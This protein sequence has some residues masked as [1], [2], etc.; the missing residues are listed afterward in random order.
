MV[1]RHISARFWWIACLLAPSLVGAQGWTEDQCVNKAKHF[2]SVALAGKNGVVNDLVIKSVKVEQDRFT[3]YEGEGPPTHLK[4]SIRHDQ[5]TQV[6]IRQENGLIT[7]VHALDSPT[8]TEFNPRHALSDRELQEMALK[9][10]RAAGWKETGMVIFHFGF[11]MD[12]RVRILHLLP[13]VR[14]VPYHWESSIYMELDYATGQLITGNW[15]K[16]PN[17]SPPT[18]LAPRITSEQAIDWAMDFVTRERGVTEAS[19]VWHPLCVCRVQDWLEY[20]NLNTHDLELQRLGQGKLVYEVLILDHT[21][22][23]GGRYRY[24]VLV[25]AADGR[26]MTI[27]KREFSGGFGGGKAMSG[28]FGWDLGDGQVRATEAGRRVFTGRASVDFVRWTHD[29]P[30]KGRTVLLQFGKVFAS[31]TFDKDTG[32]LAMKSQ[33]RIAWGRPSPDLARKLSSYKLR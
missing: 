24:D 3:I 18:D 26:I 17:V 23:D 10:H 20:S 2:L 7:V 12:P 6:Y 21:Y 8:S 27:W 32:L 5:D 4:L 25:D 9:Y 31:A 14:G 13:T 29:R 1:L 28:P 33:G 15:P 19:T 30:L 11:S 22:R 16:I